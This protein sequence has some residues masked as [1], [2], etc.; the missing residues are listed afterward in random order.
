[1]T[2]QNN[3]IFKLFRKYEEKKCHTAIYAKKHKA[4]KSNWKWIQPK[5]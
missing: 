4:Q 3:I 1:M 5:H 2:N